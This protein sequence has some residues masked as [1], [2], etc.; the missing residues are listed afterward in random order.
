MR[1]N[2][3][4]ITKNQ[5]HLIQSGFKDIHRVLINNQED[6]DFIKHYNKS[7]DPVP[8]KNQANAGKSQ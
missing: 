7:R 3:E 2:G 4:R 1:L 5:K 8:F 6:N